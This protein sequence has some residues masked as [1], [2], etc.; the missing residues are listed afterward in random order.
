MTAFL[1]NFQLRTVLCARPS[2]NIKCHFIIIILFPLYRRDVL[3]PVIGKSYQ[4]C[5]KMAIN[6]VTPTQNMNER[7]KDI[8]LWFSYRFIYGCVFIA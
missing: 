2:H 1:G 3:L 8:P 6:E 4:Q 7:L 5:L